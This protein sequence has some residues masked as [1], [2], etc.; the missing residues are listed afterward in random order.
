MTTL[1][2]VLTVLSL[3]IALALP[4][5]AHALIPIRE[6]MYPLVRTDSSPEV[7]YLL[8]QERRLV[9]P[10]EHVYRSWYGADFSSVEVLSLPAIARY[11]LT[12]LV[13]FKPGTLVKITTDPKV[14]RVEAGATLRH[15]TTEELARSLYGADWARQVHDIADIFFTSYQI[16]TPITEAEPPVMAESIRDNQRSATPPTTDP[17]TPTPPPVEPPAPAQPGSLSLRVSDELGVRPGTSILVSLFGEYQTP[18][19]LRLLVNGVPVASCEQR[20]V[21]TYELQ[22]PTQSLITEYRLQATARFMD[23]TIVERT[24]TVPVR[25]AAAGALRLTSSN[26]EA[27]TNGVINMRAEWSDPL[28]NLQRMMFV[29][30]GVE[31]HSCY[32]VQSCTYEYQLTG[33]VGTTFSVVVRGDDTAGQTWQTA[34]T[35]LAVVQN[36]RPV[37]TLGSSPLT[38]QQGERISLSAQASD[39]NGVARVQILEG[40]TVVASCETTQCSYLS[41]PT[42]QIGTRSFRA[43]AID[44]LGVT[45]EEAYAPI[46]I[47]P[48]TR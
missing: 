17:G 11:R 28:I 44:I 38:I 1:P 42:T 34:T 25:D 30:N 8:D 48:Q 18:Q 40:E 3:A 23:G 2:K 46:L 33:P 41:D 12:G 6:T 4:S 24:L 29:V 15:V 9:F 5:L 21:C 13:A 37:L 45:R 22:H 16:G 26:T 14:Y 47:L 19:S 32:S 20:P 39:E 10:N 31:Q 7:Y 43:R 35:T 27:L 36:V